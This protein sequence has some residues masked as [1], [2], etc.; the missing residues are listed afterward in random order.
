MLHS[1]LASFL[2]DTINWL[3]LQSATWGTTLT[4]A[5]AWILDHF[6]AH[7]LIA[8]LVVLGVL[9]VFVVTQLV[10][11]T[12]A[13]LKYLV[14]PSIVLAYL[15]TLFLPVTFSAALPVTVTAC[16]LVLLVKG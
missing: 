7:G 10:R 3:T 5:K 16:S 8:A 15:A 1:D 2:T 9:M 6:G 12:V 14:V 4:T 13:T 11:L